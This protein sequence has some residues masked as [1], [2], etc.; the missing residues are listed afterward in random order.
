MDT[1]ED[2]RAQLTQLAAGFVAFLFGFM[3][4][5]SL[6]WLA[7]HFHAGFRSLP[8]I[9]LGMLAGATTLPFSLVPCLRRIDVIGPPGSASWARMAGRRWAR[10][11][12]L[13]AGCCWLWLSYDFWWPWIVLGLFALVAWDYWY[14][15]HVFQSDRRRHHWVHGGLALIGCVALP[16]VMVLLQGLLILALVPQLSKSR[17]V[18]STVAEGVRAEPIFAHLS[19]PHFTTGSKLTY[20]GR[21]AGQAYFAEYAERIVE[22]GPRFVLITGDITDGGNVEQWE[23]AMKHLSGLAAKVPVVLVPGN[24]DLSTAYNPTNKAVLRSLS[25]QR[26]LFLDAV[27]TLT[28]DVRTH[29]GDRVGDFVS[30]LAPDSRIREER[31]ARVVEATKDHWIE[32]MPDRGPPRMIRVQGKTRELAERL[33][34]EG[35]VEVELRSSGVTDA[36][37]SD[38]LPLAWRCPSSKT[39]VLILDSNGATSPHLGESAIGSFGAQVERVKDVFESH[40][41]DPTIRRVVVAAHHP[42]WR[43]RFESRPGIEQIWDSGVLSV[44]PSESLGLL[45]VL[46]E[47]AIPAAPYSNGRLYVCGHRHEHLVGTLVGWQMLE[48]PTLHPKGHPNRGFDVVSRITD[49]KDEARDSTIVRW[50]DVR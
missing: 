22:I 34:T 48:A 32:S 7:G 27:G 44:K 6:L 24:H 50:N 28:P 40:R 31:E 8:Y 36:V 42:L 3:T 46:E 13:Q 37:W 26:Y 49:D 47:S 1:D 4:P 23:V 20:E 45:N 17:W 33:I 2:T 5:G 14:H 29:R 9:A 11:L 12:P 10:A 19:D 35:E 25:A 43:P 39:L 38:L 41:G 21:V 16:G 30:S 18:V 15:L